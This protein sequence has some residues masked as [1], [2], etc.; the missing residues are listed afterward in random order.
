[1]GIKPQLLAQFREKK[2]G[3]L[4][5]LAEL[6]PANTASGFVCWGRGTE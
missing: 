6:I 5:S 2:R 1:M 4:G 3:S